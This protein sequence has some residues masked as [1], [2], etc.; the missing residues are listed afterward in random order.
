MADP[1]TQPKKED[2]GGTGKTK[3]KPDVEKGTPMPDGDNKA[4]LHDVDADKPRDRGDVE[5]GA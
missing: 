1:K 5:R 4:A 3:D 2:Y